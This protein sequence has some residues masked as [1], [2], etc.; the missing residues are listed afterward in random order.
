VPFTAL[1]DCELNSF[2]STSIQ[3]K[4]LHYIHSR[5]VLDYTFSSISWIPDIASYIQISLTKLCMHLLF[6]CMHYIHKT[7]LTPLN[8][9][10][11]SI[12]MKILNVNALYMYF[13]PLFR[14][15]FKHL[16]PPC[17]Q[18]LRLQLNRL[19]ATRRCPLVKANAKFPK[20]MKSVTIV[21]EFWTLSIILSSI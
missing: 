13:T 21:S 16:P 19:H 18:T 2:W 5:L 15:T 11:F 20:I 17:F 7:F 1:K 12:K 9:I 14:Y 10:A 3:S 8:L 4:V 6:P